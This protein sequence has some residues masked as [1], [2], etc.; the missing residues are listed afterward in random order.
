MLTFTPAMTLY[1]LSCRLMAGAPLST[2]VRVISALE[3]FPA[4]SVTV[5]V[6]VPASERVVPEATEVAL[7]PVG[8]RLRAALQ[9]LLTLSLQLAARVSQSL[10]SLPPSV[11]TT[12]AMTLNSFCFTTMTGACVS[13]SGAGGVG[14][15]GGVGGRGSGPP[16]DT[17]NAT[18]TRAARRFFAALRMTV[19]AFRMAE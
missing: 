12:P 16:Q 14:G 3:A 5:S 4:S 13:F 9:D 18:A 10:S 6:S 15:E 19:C 7:P 1:S 17:M 11:A 8:V 2:L